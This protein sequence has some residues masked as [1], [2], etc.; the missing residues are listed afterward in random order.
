MFVTGLERGLVPISH[1][2]APAER[3]EERRL[4]YVALTRAERILRL[5]YAKQRTF[6]THASNRARSPWL[7]PIEQALV[8]HGPGAAPAPVKGID[9][10]RQKLAAPPRR[11]ARMHPTR[12]CSTR[13]RTGVA[14]SRASGVPAYVIF[15]DTTLHAL[16]TRPDNRDALLDV[17]GIGPVKA[18]RHGDAVLEL[19][20]RHAG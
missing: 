15:P 11:T 4:L 17:P 2:E 7:A 8:G 18:E 5:S 9:A 14:S 3:A 1:A 20:R 6:G 13:S 12:C 10:T 19:L 16:P